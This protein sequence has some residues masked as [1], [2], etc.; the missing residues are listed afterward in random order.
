M[1]VVVMPQ[2]L[3]VGAPTAT[4]GGVLSTVNVELAAL[5]VFEFP[6]TSDAVPV[7]MVMPTVPSPAQLDSVTVGVAVF[8]LFTALLQLAPPVV[9]SEMPAAVK[10]YVKPP[11]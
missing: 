1:L 9:F 2:L 8:P 5:T 3:S 6:K 7:F 4:V 11:E 10:L